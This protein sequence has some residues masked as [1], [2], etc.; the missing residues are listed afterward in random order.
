MFTLAIFAA[1]LDTIFFWGW[2][3]VERWVITNSWLKSN[4]LFWFV[5]F[6]TPVYFKTSE[7]YTPIDPGKI[8]EKK[9]PN[10]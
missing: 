7:K 1:I 6:S 9:F 4:L 2:P 5:Y 3:V 8:S 10:L